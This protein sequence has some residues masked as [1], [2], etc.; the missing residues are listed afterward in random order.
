MQAKEGKTAL[1]LSENFNGS[2]DLLLTDVIMP[3]MNGKIL[4]EQLIAQRS[5]LK[6]LYVSGHIDSMITQQGIADIN[7]DLLQKPY[8]IESLNYKIRNIFDN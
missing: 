2:I 1:S 6:V 7:S 5:D 3:Q 8:T 4:A